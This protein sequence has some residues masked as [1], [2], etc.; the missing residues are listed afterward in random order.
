M[1]LC[2]IAEIQSV[3]E[4]CHPSTAQQD[5]AGQEWPRTVARRTCAVPNTSSRWQQYYPRLCCGH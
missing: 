4:G 2:Y 1:L 5:G 3:V